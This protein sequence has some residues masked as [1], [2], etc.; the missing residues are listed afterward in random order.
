M[1]SFTEF[2]KIASWDEFFK[3]SFL[4]GIV[5]EGYGLYTILKNDKLESK[6]LLIHLNYSNEKINAFLINNDSNTSSVEILG[7]WHNDPWKRQFLLHFKNKEL[8]ELDN[9]DWIDVLEEP[10]FEKAQG[11][12]RVKPKV[13]WRHVSSAAKTEDIE[14]YVSND[15]KTFKNMMFVSYLESKGFEVRKENHF[16]SCKTNVRMH[17]YKFCKLRNPEDFERF[18]K[19]QKD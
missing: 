19:Q 13:D 1:W 17:T 3:S 15:N 10:D 18:A 7:K 2:V 11:C 12:Y 8:Q 6:P 16:V 14:V 4:R 5:K 9:Y